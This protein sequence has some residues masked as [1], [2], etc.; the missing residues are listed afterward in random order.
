MLEFIQETGLIIVEMAIRIVAYNLQVYN[1]LDYDRLGDCQ[2]V[3]MALKPFLVV[4]GSNES[5][6][7]HKD[8]ILVAQASD[9]KKILNF[10]PF[11]SNEE[12]GVGGSN[13]ERQRT[14]WRSQGEKK[15]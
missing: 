8:H 1:S 5:N 12:T 3:I 14:L 13:A 15:N 11:Y 7:I 2:V 4:Y 6:L 9:R 10:R